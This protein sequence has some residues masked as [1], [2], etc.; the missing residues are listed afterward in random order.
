MSFFSASLYRD[1]GRNWKGFGLAYLVFLLSLYL[2]PEMVRLQ[3]NFSDFLAAEAPKFVNQIP[4]ITISGGE[5]SVSKP[6]PYFI[7]N[8]DNNGPFAI[9]DTSGKFTSLDNTK[10]VVLLT[11]N[12]LVLRRDP[13]E[14]RMIDLSKIDSFVVDRKL[15]YYWLDVIK[16]WSAV[17]LYPFTLLFSFLFYSAQIILCAIIGTFLSKMLEIQL[18]RQ[19]LMRLSAVSFTPPLILQALHSILNIEFPYSS[20]IT[21]LIA[22]GYLYY[23]VSSN[24]EK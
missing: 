18:D 16:N 4:D 9:I 23:A 3:L 7:N 1:V 15:V 24:S 5:V 10:A 6:V 14:T 11:K 22:T 21:F 20:P 2:I 13:T 17:V 8:P 19:A 12:K